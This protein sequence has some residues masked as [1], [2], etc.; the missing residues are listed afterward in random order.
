MES[1]KDENKVLNA[2]ITALYNVEDRIEATQEKID[3][4][5]KKL[6]K[7]GLPTTLTQLQEKSD[8]AC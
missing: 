7:L 1:N 5:F 8:T 2:M 3:K 4:G 6:E